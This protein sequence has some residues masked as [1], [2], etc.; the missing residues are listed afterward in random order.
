MK[1][2]SKILL[3]TIFLMILVSTVTSFNVVAVGD[4]DDTVEVNGDTLGIHG[5]TK[6][7]LTL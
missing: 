2:L 3:G 4:P 6:Y 1:K 7:T 5:N